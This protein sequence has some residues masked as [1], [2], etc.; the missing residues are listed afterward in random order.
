ME[1]PLKGGLFFVCSPRTLTPEKLHHFQQG[2]RRNPYWNKYGL[3]LP[4]YHLLPL[5]EVEG[6]LAGLQGLLAENDRT[7]ILPVRNDCFATEK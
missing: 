4:V 2:R 3:N 7:G 1:S 6:L 5:E